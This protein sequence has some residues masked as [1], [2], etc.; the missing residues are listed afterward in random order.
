MRLRRHLRDI[1][2][3]WRGLRKVTGV[4]RA[5][6]GLAG[7][8]GDSGALFLGIRA[9]S[10]IVARDEGIAQRRRWRGT[11]SGRGFVKV[12]RL[13]PVITIVARVLSLNLR[14]GPK[15]LT[16]MKASNRVWREES[17]STIAAF[18]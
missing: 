5:R 9:L 18:N 6:I 3:F 16:G 1:R 2:N 8:A 7:G 13:G 15:T 4:E 17:S 12:G 14:H 10:E 11:T